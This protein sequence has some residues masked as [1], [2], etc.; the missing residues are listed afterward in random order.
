MDLCDAYIK[1]G[2]RED[3]KQL[4]LQ[5]LGA[6]KKWLGPKNCLLIY[7]Y[8]T[9]ARAY[10]SLDRRAEEGACL[11]EIMALKAWNFTGEQNIPDQDSLRYAEIMPPKS[12]GTAEKAAVTKREIED[13]YPNN[14]LPN[15][16]SNEIDEKVY[17][18]QPGDESLA[19]SIWQARVQRNGEGNEKSIEALSRLAEL[20]LHA[21]NYDEAEKLLLQKLRI[22]TDIEGNCSYYKC[23][24]LCELVCLEVT[25]NDLPKAQK[26]LNL[27]EIDAAK[28]TKNTD[29]PAP[30]ILACLAIAKYRI[31]DIDDAKTLARKA[32]D[33]LE[34]SKL[35]LIRRDIFSPCGRILMGTDYARDAYELAYYRYSISKDR[36]HPIYRTYPGFFEIK[37]IHDPTEPCE[38]LTIRSGQHSKYRPPAQIF[39]F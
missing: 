20:Y 29:E 1:A 37:S 28:I 10:K 21:Q 30:E 11:K 7:N 15:F 27:A 4:A 22:Y 9:L 18:F 26:Y 34:F 31:G 38:Q 3:A 39:N 8:E 17:N 5:L 12:W 13:K 36:E 25:K 32:L 35:T 6:Y 24:C 14:Y 16:P 33:G 23:I 19:R 2:R